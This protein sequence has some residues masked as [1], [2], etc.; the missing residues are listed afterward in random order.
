M[1][2]TSAAIIVSDPLAPIQERNAARV[3]AWKEP[4]ICEAMA[5]AT[6]AAVYGVQ[7]AFADR[8]RARAS[9]DGAEE[10]MLHGVDPQLLSPLAQGFVPALFPAL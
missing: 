10:F 1:A 5:A 7:S 6:L 3:R 2:P 9:V 4:G 8:S